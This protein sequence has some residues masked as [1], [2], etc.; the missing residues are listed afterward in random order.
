MKK[1]LTQQDVLNRLGYYLSKRKLS[2]Y[3]V[4]LR[5]GH[6]TTYFYRVQSGDI[7]LTIDVLLKVLEILEVDTEEFFCE[8]L[9]T[10]ILNKHKLEVVSGLN[11]EQ[12]SALSTLFRKS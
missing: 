10:Y 8:D 2:A 9:E 1:S 4:S 3:E 5:L 11:N 6:S 7:K 12:L